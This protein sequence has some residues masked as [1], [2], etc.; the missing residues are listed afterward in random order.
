[1]FAALFFKAIYQAPPE[2]RAETASLIPNL[3]D[4]ISASIKN[5]KPEKETVPAPAPEAVEQEETA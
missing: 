4:K 1:L 2:E 5:K 3:R